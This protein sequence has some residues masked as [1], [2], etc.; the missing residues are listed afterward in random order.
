MK[1]SPQDSTKKGLAD[2]RREGVN[3][4]PGDTAADLLSGTA[5]GGGPRAATL[6]TRVTVDA[7]AKAGGTGAELR[8]PMTRRAVTGLSGNPLA[9]GPQDFP[10][11]VDS[12]NPSAVAD[13]Q[14]LALHLS[15]AGE[16]LRSDRLEDAAAEID[17]ALALAPDDVRARNLQGLLHF[18]AGRFDE[19]LEVYHEL[20]R[21]RSGDTAL[22]LN[23]GLVELRMG[24][25][26]DAVEHLGLVV[27]A[28][29]DN[30][31][32]QGYFGLALL[33]YGD[34]PRAREVLVRAGQDELV[35]QVDR[36]LLDE[37][38][39][40]E[41]EAERAWYEQ[42]PF[43][44]SEGEAEAAI[45]LERES[46]R[47]NPTDE[48]TATTPRAS[49]EGQ[50]RAVTPAPRAPGDNRG[51]AAAAASEPPARPSSP[52]LPSA[53]P[54]RPPSP[55]L[56]VAAPARPAARPVTTPA[57]GHKA[58]MTPLDPA[59][60]KASVSATLPGRPVIL[61]PPTRL[62]TPAV[63][64]EA[65]RPQRPSKPPPPP[66]REQPKSLVDSLRPQRLAATLPRPPLSPAPG[67]PT[68][69][70][71]P[72]PTSPERPLSR[73]A[74]EARTSAAPGRV[75]RA[76]TDAEAADLAEIAPGATRP[77]PSE[78][79]PGPLV[80]SVSVTESG[81]SGDPTPDPARGA[82][83][84]GREARSAAAADQARST[85]V[86]DQARSAAAAGARALE[87]AQPFLTPADE[88]A[89]SG[90][91]AAE[92]EEGQWQVSQAAA[93][94]PAP[95]ASSRSPLRPVPAHALRSLPPRSAPLRGEASAALP[96]LS[97]VESRELSPP[98]DG[99]PFAITGEGLLLIGV[100]GHLPTRSVGVIVSS[101][102]LTYDPLSRR[103]RGRTLNET[104]G[105]GVTGM[106]RASGEGLMVISP[107][108]GHFVALQ[109]NEESLYVRES[110]TFAFED[111]LHF[112][113]GRL[114]GSGPAPGYS[115]P[116]LPDE[117]GRVVQLRGSGQ[118][119]LRT[120][121]PLFTVRLA[122]NQ[123]GFIEVEQL[124]GWLGRVI[125]SLLTDE[126]GLPTPYVECSG[127]GYLLVEPPRNE[128]TPPVLMTTPS[129][130]PPP[131]A[132]GGE[133]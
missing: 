22:R 46:S 26:Q 51:S 30:L 39:A 102:E 2:P 125:P 107:R 116:G 55:A 110:V 62:A 13:E 56:P 96:L 12:S 78:S 59:L 3:P 92:R 87:L 42:G 123:T 11:S 17:M 60:A 129:A 130:A 6:A 131:P 44:G 37:Q 8:E 24:N 7:V 81:R 100:R 23:L 70:V 104:F 127:E 19:A 53:S 49:A 73:P 10:S 94:L 65:L 58:L 126:N 69:Q 66:A 114:P 48:A 68:A 90:A 89:T 77:K 133:G 54:A 20:L 74:A 83:A 47:P 63:K 52:A 97:F 106:F 86:I 95:P 117:L 108:G 112:E 99:S 57:G 71:P 64:G 33:R 93:G 35:T 82:A 76:L 18:R 75:A 120:E 101:G 105:D 1:S 14:E 36:M 121:R 4:A 119:V 21:E 25:Y 43:E 124:V 5:P 31:R 128:P 41:E 45:P 91:V 16:Y 28:E 61:T 32:A 38:A 84:D 29:P 72:M 88:A 50:E 103:A 40:A 80:A 9:G 132:A 27:E 122:S 109:L 15:R 115:Y 118:L 67:A 111:E 98:Q 85:A 79:A 113:N 34:L